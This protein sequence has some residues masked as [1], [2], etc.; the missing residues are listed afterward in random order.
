MGSVRGDGNQAVKRSFVLLNGALKDL[1]P[2]LNTVPGVS[3]TL[4]SQVA[5]IESIEAQ[6]AVV[7]TQIVTDGLQGKRDAAIAKMVIALGDS[8]NLMVIAEGVETQEQ[9]EYLAQQ[10]C[11]AYQGYLFGRPMAVDAFET[12]AASS[13]MHCADS[14]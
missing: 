2:G 9:R 6:Y 11:L 13:H 4:R 14:G 7:A 5:D 10:G 3:D 12:L 1:K 8:L